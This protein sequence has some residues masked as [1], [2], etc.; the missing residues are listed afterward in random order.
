MYRA[1]LFWVK[2]QGKKDGLAYYA[3]QD[4]FGGAPRKEDLG[5]PL[6]LDD[7]DFEEWMQ[8]RSEKSRREWQRE[9]ARRR[10][11]GKSS[12]APRGGLR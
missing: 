11:N 10:K 5:D 8:L 9:K 4:M 2:R 1:M 3:F 6:H 12:S 7:P